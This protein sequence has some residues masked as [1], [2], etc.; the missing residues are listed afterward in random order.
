MVS[1]GDK[2][3]TQFVIGCD[4]SCKAWK[5]NIDINV[6]ANNYVLHPS[7]PLTIICV[8]TFFAPIF[9]GPILTPLINLVNNVWWKQKICRLTLLPERHVH[10]SAQDKKKNLQSASVLHRSAPW[11]EIFFVKIFFA[12]ISLRPILIPLPNLVNNVCGN[13]RY[14]SSHSTTNT[15]P[16]DTFTILK[17]KI[18]KCYVV[19]KRRSMYF[20]AQEL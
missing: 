9:L 3:E 13:G 1:S 14:A 11:I 10:A 18:C 15:N 8:E 20:E 2:F 17:P 19:Q 16:T 12:T 6:I 5:N 7:A 4:N